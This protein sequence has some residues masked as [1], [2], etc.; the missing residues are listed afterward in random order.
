LP[1]PTSKAAVFASG[2][3]VLTE[4]FNVPTSGLGG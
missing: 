4:G 2:V 3:H 1:A